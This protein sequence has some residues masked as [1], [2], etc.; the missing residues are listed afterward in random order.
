MNKEIKE[1]RQ[2]YM[3]GV[4]DKKAYAD[5]MMQYHGVLMAYPDLI[6]RSPYIQSIEISPEGVILNIVDDLVMPQA[7]KMCLSSERD[8]RCASMWVLDFGE[9]E[10]T[11]LK[12]FRRITDLINPR[13][14]F[15]IGA[16]EGWYSF[17]MMKQFPHIK[18]Y[19]FEPVYQTY[20]RAVKNL[21]INGQTTDG[22]MNIGLSD[23]NGTAYFYFNEAETGAAS[24]RNIRK[25]D[26]ESKI[27]CQLRRLDDIVSEKNI[28]SMDLIKCDVEGNELFALKGGLQSIAKFKPVI[29][30][31]MLR[32][33]CADFGYH[34]NDII[35]LLKDLGYSCYRIVENRLKE[36]LTVTDETIETNFFFLHT[37]KHGNVIVELTR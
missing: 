19:S 8:S 35:K 3:E 25:I 23:K 11:E 36:I 15:D 1:L 5:A 22:L 24:L 32:K 2:R 30:C 29:F 9:V 34:P 7:V 37:D 4:M 28:D 16:N 31:E 21:R 10:A 20:E 17:H 26:N 6:T 27:E 18:C 33:W 13:S 12:M 14:F